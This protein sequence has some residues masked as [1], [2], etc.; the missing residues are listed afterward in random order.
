MKK[1][2][3]V[4]FLL[5]TSYVSIAQVLKKGPSKWINP[6]DYITETSITE[7]QIN[8]GNLLLLYDEQININR[9]EIYFH[10]ATKITDNVGVQAASSIQI[11][12]DPSYQKLIIHS[13]KIIR[14]DEVIDKI[15]TSHFQN[16]R[17]ELNAENYIYDGSYTALTNLSDVR[18]GDIVE[19]SYS[20][21]GFNPIHQGKFSAVFNLNSSQPI[22]LLSLKLIS[23]NPIKT[24]FFNTNSELKVQKHN[25]KH[26]YSYVKKNVESFLP[27]NNQPIWYISSEIL[28]VST[29]KSWKEI[30][31]WGVKNFNVNSSLSPSLKKKISEINSENK[32]EG[33]KVTAVLNFVQDEIRYL[34]LENGIGAYKPFSPN[35]VFKQRYGDCK[36]KSLLMS[37]MLNELGIE[38]YPMLVNTYLKSSIKDFLPATEHFN[39]CVVKVIDKNKTQLYYDPT[40]SNQGGNHE[41]THFPNYRQGLV[42]KPGND[43]FD[44]ITSYANNLVEIVDNIYIDKN[45]K[46]GS[47]EIT[48]TYYGH[49][50]NLIRSYFK[51]NSIKSIQKEYEKYYS[52]HFNEVRSTS[53]PKFTDNIEENSLVVRETYKID[54]LWSST[55][56][57]DKKTVSFHPYSITEILAMPSKTSRETPFALTFP[58][59]RHHTIKVHLPKHWNISQ[60]SFNINSPSIYYD[61]DVFYSRMNKVVSIEHSLKIKKDHVA[62]EDFHEFYND[63]KDIDKQ[64]TYNFI[65]PKDGANTFNETEQTSSIALNILGSFIF[66]TILGLFIFLAFKLYNYNPQPKIE[67]YFEDNKQIGGWL[68]LLGIGLCLAP[69]KIFIQVLFEENYITGGWIM[70]LTPNVFQQNPSIAFITLF[71]LVLNT[72]MFVYGPLAIILF[73]QRRS[74]FPKVHAIYL[75]IIFCSS[76]IIYLMAMSLYK[77][78]YM[79]NYE[80]NLLLISFIFSAIVIPYL[81]TADR[82]KE[83]FVKTKKERL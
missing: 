71:R 36:D 37:T 64:I 76:L 54:N 42:L 14:E 4:S 58:T 5:L 52:K 53:L 19:Y 6:V 61:Q 67:K 66:L 68:I 62:V 2:L 24:K 38:A 59:E 75:G 46:E 44:D 39:H 30:V 69:L 41:N 20:I 34:G 1:L 56:E 11:D 77:Y 49:D 78:E 51:N 72:L 16:I 26:T 83:T 23:N 27:E 74:S 47:L 60:N 32:S 80:T 3:L 73:F 43:N 28:N 13:L 57:D 79:K 35:K 63:L 21:K 10:L 7:E 65:V 8:Q 17:R 45:G 33:E 25:G 81:L 12:Y 70:Y 29:Y 50:A 55:I 31:D 48:S 82:V 15:K 18:S 40:I 22:G 9:E